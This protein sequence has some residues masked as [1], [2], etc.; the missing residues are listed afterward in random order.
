MIQEHSECRITIAAAEK[1]TVRI[2]YHFDQAWCGPV[3]IEKASED[4]LEMFADFDGHDLTDAI[5][6]DLVGFT[7]GKVVG[8]HWFLLSAPSQT[9]LSL[10]NFCSPFQR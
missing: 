3:F 10:L 9:K 7:D 5:L 8:S 6:P 1:L 4:R 2:D